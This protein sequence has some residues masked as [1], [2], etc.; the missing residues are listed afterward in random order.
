MKGDS[1]EQGVLFPLL[2]LGFTAFWYLIKSI[3]YRSIVVGNTISGDFFTWKTVTATFQPIT[4]A[5]VHVTW[6]RKAL[7]KHTL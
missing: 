5:F 3:S 4:D 2:T 6:L 7:D 1:I